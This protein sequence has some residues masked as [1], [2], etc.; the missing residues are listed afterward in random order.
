[1]EGFEVSFAGALGAGI[2]SF[3]SPCVL[4]L[5]PAYICFVGGASLDELMDESPEAKKVV[6]HIFVAAL[7]FV[8]GFATVFV[9][10]GLTASWVSQLIAQHKEVLARVAGIVIVL[11]GLHFAGVFRIG[12]LNFEKRYH[13]AEKP[14]GVFGSYALGL[15]FAF[16]WTP[17]V[18]PVL[19]TILMVAAMGDD[20]L[21][22]AALLGTYAA[23][24]GIPFLL[25]ATAVKPFMLF[26]ARFKRH[27]RKVEIGIGGLLVLT[28]CLIFF[29][30]MA[31]IG[32]WLLET[33][34]SL[35]K[36]G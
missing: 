8:L 18:G 4:P 30:S 32:Q 6:R 24:I 28:G 9:A 2:L 36:I 33:F 14:A 1:M 21:Y 29:G 31:D 17:C 15:A 27:M 22:G 16:G 26:M 34:P 35:G 25:A 3:V 7:A 5:V 19:A 11:F 20:P 13:V 23:G 10:L 12:F